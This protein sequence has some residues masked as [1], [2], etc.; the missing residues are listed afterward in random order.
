MT[1]ALPSVARP[2]A[3]R[4]AAR[5]DPFRAAL[6]PRLADF[7]RTSAASNVPR[8]LAILAQDAQQSAAV[9]VQARLQRAA[10]AQGGAP[11]QR[12]AVM[13]PEMWH[14]LSSRAGRKRSDALLRIDVALMEYHGTIDKDVQTQKT[15]A[16][17]LRTAIED[18]IRDKG[19]KARDGAAV[20]DSSRA[21]AVEELKDQLGKKIEKLDRT[22]SKGKSRGSRTTFTYDV[23]TRVRGR[24]QRILAVERPSM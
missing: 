24:V 9:A 20:I 3:G 5:V 16:E 15:A 2:T 13:T 7:Y 6:D 21:K 12:Q 8:G 4:N 10:D 11:F 1:R 19:Y 23:Y 22:L 17:A 18:W 14:S